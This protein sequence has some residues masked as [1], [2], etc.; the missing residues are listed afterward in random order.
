MLWPK[1]LHRLWRRQ[2]GH[3][4]SSSGTSNPACPH[5][6]LLASP[7]IR[8]DVLPLLQSYLFG[9]STGHAHATDGRGGVPQRNQLCG[10]GPLRRERRE[11]QPLPSALQ[12]QVSGVPPSA[13]ALLSDILGAHIAHLSAHRLTSRH[14]HDLCQLVYPLWLTC[15][16][17]V[18]P[19]GN[20]KAGSR[21]GLWPHPGAPL[22]A[23][24]ARPEGS[25]GNHPCLPA[26][27]LSCPALCLNHS[28][29]GWSR[30]RAIGVC[31]RDSLKMS[32]A[33]VC[34]CRMAV[35]YAS[36]R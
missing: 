21:R 6:P 26:G 24:R 33:W 27:V 25:S 31:Y 3:V 2:A 8:L 16:A 17:G 36:V 32:N 23:H 29:V 35:S 22:S 30:T 9:A 34:P 7:F 18:G 12:A 14:C 10:R 5:A 19:P 28:T 4:A 1:A 11:D 13:K 20:L 15:G